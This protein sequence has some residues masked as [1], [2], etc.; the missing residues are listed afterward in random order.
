MEPI[1]R[2]SLA[3][4]SSFS[5]VSLSFALIVQ[6]LQNKIKIAVQRHSLRTV[7]ARCQAGKTLS[8]AV[9]HLRR[10]ESGGSALFS[11]YYTIFSPVCQGLSSIFLPYLP[12]FFSAG[13]S[14]SPTDRGNGRSSIRYD[15]SVH[16]KSSQKT[17][18]RA[19]N[20]LTRM[21][22]HKNIR[23]F[24]SQLNIY[25]SCLVRYNIYAVGNRWQV[26][27]VAHCKVRSAKC[28]AHD[29][30]AQKRQVGVQFY[31]CL[32]PDG[33]GQS[34]P[35]PPVSRAQAAGPP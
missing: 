19:E 15:K 1:S 4:I 7:P 25:K 23:G 17:G 16:W 8:T 3:V 21:L 13:G 29:I 34:A 35:L 24:S 14:R 18:F 33:A 28:Q 6:H 30:S 5:R 32:P 27:S 10:G 2:I 31:F 12:L 11:S 20:F 26:P 22:F 9:A